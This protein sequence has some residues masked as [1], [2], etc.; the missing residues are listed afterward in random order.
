MHPVPSVCD[1]SKGA[2]HPDIPSGL[3]LCVLLHKF[4][5]PVLLFREGKFLALGIGP[6]QLIYDYVLN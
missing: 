5:E 3:D 1:Q 4:Y 2:R 6:S